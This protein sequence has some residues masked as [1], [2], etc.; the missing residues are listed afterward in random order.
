MDE[1]LPGVFA[2][3]FGVA[4][5]VLGLVQPF[6]LR[7]SLWAVAWVLLVGG[8]IWWAWRRP[9][10]LRGTTRRVA[11]YWVGTGLLY[12]VALFVGT[13][14]LIGQPLYWVPAALVVAAPLAF[15]SVRERHA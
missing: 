6:A 7:M 12:G 13:P 9:A 11:G 3:G 4:T 14:R 1:Y 15:G 2:A 8:M 5:L 10:N